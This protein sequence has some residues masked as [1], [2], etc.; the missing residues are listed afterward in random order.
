MEELLK[1]MM[2][3][4]NQRFDAVDMRFEMID[5][6]FDAVDKRFDKMD[7][8]INSLRET[9]ENNATEFR[10]HFRYVEKKLEQHDSM[11][12]IV[13]GLSKNTQK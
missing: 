7:A 13:V 11:F 3:Q 2:D 6:R 10:S 12:E 8:D 5:E 4:M 1:Q 9:V